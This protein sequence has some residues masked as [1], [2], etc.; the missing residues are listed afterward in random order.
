MFRHALIWGKQ[1]N[2]TPPHVAEEFHELLP[3]SKLYWID[4]CGHAP[5]MEQPLE[6]NKILNDYLEG[7][8]NT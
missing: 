4:K 5:M 6:F 7:L 2:I 1:D 3:D 8:F